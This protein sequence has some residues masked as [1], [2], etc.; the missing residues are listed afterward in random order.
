M[1]KEE[2]RYYKLGQAV[3]EGIQM[4]GLTA[5]FVTTFLIGIMK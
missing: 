4:I 2:R 5:M 3:V 1:T